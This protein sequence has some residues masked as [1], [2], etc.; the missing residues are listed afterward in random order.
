MLA[1]PSYYVLPK[2]AELA[3]KLKIPLLYVQ[4]I[5][6][7]AHFVLQLPP[8][9]PIVDTHPDPTTTQDLRL[10]A[11]WPELV[12]FAQSYTKNLDQLSDHDHGHVPYLLL[13]LHYLDKWKVTHGGKAPTSDEKIELRKMVREGA[14]TNNAEG[15]EENYDEAAGAV[16]KSLN[17]PSVPSGLKEIFAEEECNSPT[18]S[19]WL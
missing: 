3:W 8:L 17:A 14:R 10:V 5:G 18:V 9:F 13:L 12:E 1:A 6:F 16:L 19:V 7:Y 11:P 4:S 15:G 2:I